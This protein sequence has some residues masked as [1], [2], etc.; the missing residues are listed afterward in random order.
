MS[1]VRTGISA[2]SWSARCT[3]AI[4]AVLIALSGA[5]SAQ[6]QTRPPPDE[7]A[8]ATARPPADGLRRIEAL[9][10]EAKA[11]GWTFQ[12]AY[13]PA[14][15]RPLTQLAA[16]VV[17]ADFET[18]AREWDEISRR[19]GHIEQDRLSAAGAN[20]SSG[21]A[22]AMA[23]SPLAPLCN[24]QPVMSPIR[25]QGS[26]GSCWAFAAMGAWE[27]TYSLRYGVKYDTSEQHILTC[28]GAGTCGGGFYAGVYTWMTN[29][30]ARSEVQQA[31]IAANGACAI[32]PTG[33]YKVANWN[34][35]V[36]SPGPAPVNALKLA[37]VTHG[38][39][40]T[41]IYATGAF[42]GYGGGVFNENANPLDAN[43]N[44]SINHAVVIVGW[45]DAK[46]AWRVRN[47]W[48]GSWGE[49]G[50]AWVTYGSNNI[51]A[52]AA[53]VSPVK[54]GMP[55]NPVDLGHKV[56]PTYKN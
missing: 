25:N 4:L 50:Y 11:K 52:Y 46:G 13:N 8:S 17:P 40:V 45:D 23:C 39:L 54:V 48:S 44:P 18:K 5:A 53:W 14:V 7:A 42:Q 51:G 38:P 26:C 37:L 49:A 56:V 55:W 16:T 21:A 10:A 30:A 1:L 27:G 43:G 15:D 36:T 19:L 3:A 33:T 35:V 34:Y 47:S 6:A 9:R 29:Y 22:T 41:T 24:Y 32:M 31:Y 2:D 28:A 20:Q 12:L